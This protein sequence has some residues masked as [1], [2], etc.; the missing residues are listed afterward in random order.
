LV[1][2]RFVV[3]LVAGVAS[4]LVAALMAAVLP[5]SPHAVSRVLDPR[6][7]LFMLAL[8]GATISVMMPFVMRFGLCGVMIFMLVLQLAGVAAFALTLWFDQRDG[9]RPV[10]N[11]LK[12]ALTGLHQGLTTPVVILETALV[13]AVGIW[14]SFRLSVVMAERRDA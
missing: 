4:F 2:S 5:W 1:L 3:A 12:Q 6:T 7:L 14:L 11:A 13:V 10:I 8:V 9:M